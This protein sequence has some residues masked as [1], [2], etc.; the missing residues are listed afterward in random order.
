[1]RQVSDEMV[2]AW[3]GGDYVSDDTRAFCRVTCQVARMKLHHFKYNT[4]ASFVFGDGHRPKEVPNLKGLNWER[5]IDQDTATATFTFYNTAPLPLGDT[6][7]RDLDIPG[8]YTYNRGQTKF[9][10][11]WDQESNEWQGMLMPDNILRTYEGYGFDPDVIP[12]LDP[13]LVS[14]GVWRID[15][16]TF[17]TDGL[18]TVECRDIGS[19]L[20]DQIVF[21][22]VVPRNFYPLSFSAI[23]KKSG[24]FQGYIHSTE[25]SITRLANI[26]SWWHGPT[27]SVARV[28]VED[29]SKKF[30]AVIH[31]HAGDLPPHDGYKRVGFRFVVDGVTD[32]KVIPVDSES[33]DGLITRDFK[34][35]TNG[36]V[37]IVNVRDVW[38]DR[39]TKQQVTVN[40]SPPVEAHPNNAGSTIVPGSIVKNAG[41]PPTDPDDPVVPLEGSIAW[42]YTGTPDHFKIVLHKPDHPR[43]VFTTVPVGTHRQYLQ[44]GRNDLSGWSILV[45][46]K[47]DNGDV[48]SGDFY[49]ESGHYLGGPLVDKHPSKK[50]KNVKQGASVT[51]KQGTTHPLEP[52]RLKIS[53]SDSSNTYYEGG[54]DVTIYGHAPDDAFD[55]HHASYWL[56]I[57]NFR[58]D[59]G[60]SYE[61]I[62]GKVK[63]VLLQQ[64]EFT[65]VKTGYHAY[66]SVYAD[67]GWIT[68][69][70]KVI[71]YDPTNPES[72]NGGNVP[73][74]KRVA[75]TEEGPNTVTL[76]KP[77][78]NVTKVRIT[79]HNLQY[80]SVG[81]YH[82]RA[83]V[84]SFKVFGDA[85]SGGNELG[86]QGDDEASVTLVDG[87]EYVPPR[88]VPGAG[89]KPGKYEDYT[90][91]V[92]LF[93]A[94]GGF[95]WP[96]D[97]TIKLSD[98][99][100]QTYNFGTKYGFENLDPVLG[101]TAGRV[102]GDFEDTGTAGIAAL[103][104]PQWDKKSLMDGINYV[105]EIIGNVFY[106]DEDGAVVW[107]LPNIFRVG[108]YV[109]NVAF[110]A[111]RSNKIYSI[112]EKQTLISL[113]A[114]VSGRN[115]REKYF[116]ADTTGKVGALVKGYNPNPVG[117]RRV[118]GWTDQHFGSKAEC[119]IM[120]DLIALR[121][122]LTY[123][124][125]QV[126]IPGFPA[127]QVDDQI[128][129]FEQTAAEG[130]LH[131]VKG[132]SS[133]MD[134][135]TGRWTYTLDT[136]WL[137]E[138][139]HTKWIYDPKKLSDETR[140]YLKY[141]KI[142]G[143]SPA[144]PG[145]G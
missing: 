24:I 127:I 129:I 52:K 56:S 95:F 32:D 67:G 42:R 130:Y 128:R 64:V 14:S 78:P 103:P 39:S 79:F 123:R 15:D 1:M 66:I 97:G 65:T 121:A 74:V 3:R 101:K 118:G 16:V 71:P 26:P 58:A 4:Y 144:N 51:D 114:K 20:I 33:W 80:F 92:K 119:R 61:W 135:E 12:E 21:K 72:H 60:Y 25:E 124:T 18:I 19:I 115:V 112:D 116:I 45:Y 38:E 41:P 29:H 10:K 75:V 141:L 13:H 83:A 68:L 28:T 110:G 117:L 35:L 55:D 44:T 94:W 98:G 126:V 62:E 77:I 100:V 37:Y 6:P 17:S 134:L 7:S 136:Q 22:P 108:N 46:P 140:K 76:H 48:G 106:I 70:D 49:T 47:H 34:R 125:D 132:I 122:L 99:S 57:G 69:D 139:P 53:L 11:R 85:S 138:N 23:K 86:V 109:G 107:R 5:G 73:Y 88:I 82:Y 54:K 63:N 8:Y 120:A 91:I 43:I 89:Q 59:Q 27:E 84:R 137:G 133:E 50:A 2:A 30:T 143:D 145:S 111:V 102:W 81:T 31:P 93:C 96:Q 90:D 113:G 87:T 131:Y 104:V 40:A 36:N 142:V 105:R 9:A